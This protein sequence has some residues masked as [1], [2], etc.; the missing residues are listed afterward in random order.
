LTTVAFQLSSINT[1]QIIVEGMRNDIDSWFAPDPELYP[2]VVS[3]SFAMSANPRDDIDIGL[4]SMI[5]R[6]SITS[7][8]AT[9]H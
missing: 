7:L 8:A 3:T 9:A 1:T 5:S 4:R 6:A 2:A